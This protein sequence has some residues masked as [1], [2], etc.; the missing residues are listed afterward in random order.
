MGSQALVQLRPLLLLL[1]G[2]VSLALATCVVKRASEDAS[3]TPESARVA[4]ASPTP[5]A[6]VSANPGLAPA[7]SIAHR[8]SSA[9]SAP[10]ASAKPALNEPFPMLPSSKSGLPIP[11]RQLLPEP[12]SQPANAPQAQDRAP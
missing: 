11:I 3:P 10:S 8:L 6:A 1:T 2:G 12:S 4:T 7:T 9:S 5:A